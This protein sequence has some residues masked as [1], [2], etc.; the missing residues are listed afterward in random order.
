MWLFKEYKI[1]MTHTLSQI[2]S[3][4]K[5]TN[6]VRVMCNSISL[7]KIME[8]EKKLRKSRCLLKLRLIA[9]DSGYGSYKRQIASCFQALLL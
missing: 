2:E 7:S 6:S 5:K 4:W 1:N 9:A 8:T 3:S